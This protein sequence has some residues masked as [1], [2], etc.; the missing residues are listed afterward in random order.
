M[1]VDD[2]M[3][4]VWCEAFAT[5]LFQFERLRDSYPEKAA[6]CFAEKAVQAFREQLSER[7]RG[8]SCDW[9]PWHEK[10]I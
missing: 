5:S 10:T 6:W 8:R 4:V 2:V 9:L 1:I 3:G 7:R